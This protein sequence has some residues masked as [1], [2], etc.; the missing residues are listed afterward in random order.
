M[1]IDLGDP[2]PK[3]LEVAMAKALHVGFGGARGGGKS[4][5]IRFNAKGMAATYPG[6]RQL[7]IRKTYPELREN[8]IRI[9]VPET[10][11]YAKYKDKDKELTFN[12]GS[13]VR[14][15]YCDND[16]DADRL[17]G[18]EFDIIYFD[19]ATQLTEY[20]L[21]TL[22]ACLRG[23]NDFPKHIYYTCNPGGV[24]HSY[25]KRIFIDKNYK[26]EEDPNDYEFIQSLVDDNQ[27]L[28]E[29][30]PKYRKRLEAL[31][32]KQRK[33]WLDGDWDI[34]EGQFFEEFVDDPEHYAKDDQRWTHVIEPFNIPSH[35]NIYR[36][37]DWGYA[38]PFSCGWWAIDEEGV[39]YR[40]LELYGC[41]GE[42]DEGVKWTPDKQFEEI[43]KIEREHPLLKGRQITDGVADPACWNKETGIS[44]MDT[45][46]KYGIYFS[47]G[48]NKRLAGWMQMHYRFQFDENGYPRMYIF[49]TCKNFIRTIP[50]LMYSESPSK[51]EDLDTTQ[52]DHI[53]D[54][55]RYMCMTR[56]IEP[57]KPIEQE[58][59]LDDPLNQFRKRS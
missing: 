1:N 10:L 18:A 41:T 32:Y 17:Q 3:Q 51:I 53:A 39:M 57:L 34:F 56:P 58:T 35:W 7:I 12:N 31:P 52:E 21:Q 43:S 50:L 14:F 5:F 48:D 28:L 23:V 36:S 47:K 27:K 4:W 30:D 9:L 13:V 20:Q 33:A 26:D 15:M 59:I 22:T 55:T 45:A 46:A 19:E 49:N 8:H 29:A 2:Q 54:E 24:G 6:I 37:Y 40:I 11:G 16:N 25:I 38:K 44:V 42:A